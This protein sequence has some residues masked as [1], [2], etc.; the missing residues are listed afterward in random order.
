MLQL[1]DPLLFV[2]LFMFAFQFSIMFFVFLCQLVEMLPYC[3]LFGA[4]DL[5]PDQGNMLA[6]KEFEKNTTYIFTIFQ[7]TRF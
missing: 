2:Y 5:L 4:H 3:L 6:V 7:V 1:I